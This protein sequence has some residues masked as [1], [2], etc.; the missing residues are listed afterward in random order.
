MANHNSKTDR[1]SF[2]ENSPITKTKQNKTRSKLG[3]TQTTNGTGKRISYHEVQTG[4]M[5]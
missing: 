4:S 3:P 2:S 5:M 1:Y